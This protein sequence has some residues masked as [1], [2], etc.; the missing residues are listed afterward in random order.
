MLIS[1]VGWSQ[2]LSAIYKCND[3]KTVIYPSFP[4]VCRW[5]I[6]DGGTPKKIFCNTVSTDFCSLQVKRGLSFCFLLHLNYYL[7]FEK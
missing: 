3:N 6:L 1:G 2:F 7:L 4:C 5:D